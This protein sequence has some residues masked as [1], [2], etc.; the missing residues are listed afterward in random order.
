MLSIVALLAL[1]ATW[2]LTR[3]GGNGGG[4]A[5]GSN[6][7]N[8]LPSI[9][10]GPSGSGPAISQAPGG[11]DESGDGETSGAGSGSGDDGS[12]AGSG[13]GGSGDSAGSGSG[14]GSGSGGS[15][16]SGGGAI[17]DGEGG[18]TGTG[19][20]LPAGSKLPDC[21]GGAVK[22]GVRSLKNAYE[23]GDRPTFEL[24]VTNTSGNDC[25]VDLG[26]KKTV[27][28][29][30]QADGDDTLWSSAD[31]PENAG[32]RLFRVPADSRITHTVTWDRKP[33]EPNCATPSAGS[34]GAGTYLVE[35]EAPNLAKAQTS[36]VLEKD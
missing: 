17:A 24:A 15:G 21:T 10:A 34:A 32:S 27:L 14:S 1:L 26:P 36:F 16:S 6:G 7:K 29:I 30:A 12:A 25:K 11:R 2:V 28:T 5:N 18:G 4:D 35:A 9:T 20:R 3:G 31:C 8:P 22:L 23:P 19:Q 13:D 33:S